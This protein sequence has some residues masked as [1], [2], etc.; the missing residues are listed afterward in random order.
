MKRH[1]TLLN[2]GDSGKVVPVEIP[3]FVIGRS[4]SANFQIDD[5]RV[6]RHHLELQTRD[7]RVFAEDKSTRWSNLNGKRLQGVVP[8]SNGDILEVGDIRFRYEESA[9]EPGGSPDDAQPL[10][11]GTSGTKFMERIDVLPSGD[12]GEAGPEATRG[13]VGEQTRMLNP[14]DLPKWQAPATPERRVR[15][16]TLVYG[17]AA[18][19]VALGAGL[20][21]FFMAQKP[22]LDAGGAQDHYT[23][24][25]F[26]F[27]LS[28]PSSWTRFQALPDTP[29]IVG[30]GRL[31]GATWT[32]LRVDVD[33]G[34]QYE[35]TGLTEGFLQYQ[36]SVKSNHV[37]LGSKPM[38]VNDVSCIFYGFTLKNGQGKGLYLIN[39]G[40]RI[41]V[42][43]SS[44]TSLY[45]QQAGLFSTLLM[46]FSLSGPQQFLDFPL[47]D[48]A[49]QKMGLGDPAGVARLIDEHKRNGDSLVAN[50][51]VKPD[52]LPRAIQ[53]YKL[54]LQLSIAR[55]ERALGYEETAY[56]LRTALGYYSQAIQ[57]QRF[58]INRALKEG[59]SETAYWAAS[60][61]LLMLPDK[62]DPDYQ[63]IS[64]LVRGL[65]LKK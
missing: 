43:G 40:L 47:P 17:L 22:V 2:G 36:G 12:E 41:I 61:L 34:A 13:I 62:Q 8:L 51:N 1:L 37:F 56:A 58:E 7:D 25:V 29:L 30:L 6:S 23:D 33:R 3:L 39:G 63:E 21:W 5:P 11:A 28:Y 31:D 49:M 42:E 14:D 20:V 45:Q 4:R 10:S 16:R 65:S 46:S 27:G 35:T 53:A 32:R 26:G 38:K 18:L 60:K 57:R 15:K 19:A 64:Q 52:N 59:D 54:A 24:P 55:P 50:R 44:S 9:D 48:D